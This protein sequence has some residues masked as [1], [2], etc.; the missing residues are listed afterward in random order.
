MMKKLFFFFVFFAITTCAW[1]EQVKTSFV[2]DETLDRLT[3]RLWL[4]QG[5]MIVK[6]TATSSDKLGDATIEIFDDATNI[7]LPIQTIAHPPFTDTAASMYRQDFDNVTKGGGAIQLVSGKTYFARCK[8]NYGGAQGNAR[9]FETG[10]TF[11]VTMVQ[12]LA[13]AS[14]SIAGIQSQVMGIQS[15]VNQETTKTREKL[16]QLDAGADNTLVASETNVP[17]TATTTAPV[18]TDAAAVAKSAL[19]NRETSV[20]SGETIVIRYRTFPGASPLIT[21]Y[22]PS[23][24]IRV[25][26]G[27]MV[28]GSQAGIYSYPVTF[29]R[30]WPVGDYTIVCSVPSH[31][32]MEAM[33]LTV[34]AS[35]IETISSDVTAGTGS[36]TPAQGALATV[37]PLSDALDTVEKNLVQV[38]ETLTAIESGT[39]LSGG[40]ANRVASM[41]NSLKELSAKIK[42]LG[43][44][45]SDKL[46]QMSDA[47]ATDY[48]YLRNKTQELKALLD[49]NKQLL[50]GTAKEG[51]VVKTWMEFR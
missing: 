29:Q 13:G 45:S 23:H 34:K 33:T 46:F 18:K 22:D 26:G 10:A 27:R 43:G 30:T 25:A 48:D 44:V 21:V 15:T 36:A 35:S 40:V 42:S 31:G 37:K 51:M 38:A 2:F 19:L 3:V 12:S 7:W 24:V 50:E 11:T 6:N 28:E 49:I 4:D 9:V 47:R 17:S 20:F 1:A 41:Y 39:D 14:S 32:T 8:I 16:D 5:G